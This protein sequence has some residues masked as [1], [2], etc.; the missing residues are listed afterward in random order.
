M[1]EGKSHSVDR[2]Q[3]AGIEVVEDAARKKGV[4]IDN[5]G[6]ENP[7]CGHMPI[8]APEF[9]QPRRGRQVELREQV[10]VEAKANGAVALC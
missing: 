4:L 1:C 3:I 5:T 9:S 2:Q 10:P 6:G 8:R 7:T